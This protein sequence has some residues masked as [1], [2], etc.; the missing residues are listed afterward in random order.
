[1]NNFNDIFNKNYDFKGSAHAR[2]NLI[3]EH[4]DYTGGY[5][6]PMLLKYKTDV[7]ISK[8]KTK[9]LFIQ[10]YIMRLKA[11]TAF[12]SLKITIGQTILKDAFLP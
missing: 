7:Y 4:T 12:T 6:L 10:H 1:M 8:I 3:G 9:I 11:L 5:V 2:V